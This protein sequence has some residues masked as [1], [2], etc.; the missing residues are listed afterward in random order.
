[1]STD[2][3]LAT[4]RDAFVDLDRARDAAE[5]IA[6]QEA[7]A[8]LAPVA[9]SKLRSY[10]LLE[11]APGDAVLDVGCGSGY[12]V[13]AL[14]RLVAPGRAVG[15]DRSRIA[16]TRAQERHGGP[17]AQFAVADAG[18]LPFPDSSFAAARSERALQHM[19]APGRALAEMARVTR[20][21]GRV[22]AVEMRS[23][24]VGH[25]IL[26]AGITQALFGHV[27]GRSGWMGNFLPPL[28]KRAGLVDV[29]LFWH[30]GR[31]AGWDAL[32]TVFAFDL[33]LDLAARLSTVDPE[34]AERWAEACRQ[35]CAAGTLAAQMHVVLAAGR[36]P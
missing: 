6:H 19:Q 18:A 28:F 13:A 22:V 30:E 5:L 14:A 17:H 4:L 10:E 16:I 36:V 11:L 26:D 23:V 33:L 1:V 20:P 12:D 7:M 15:V 35:A 31:V 27:E 32:R 8:Q 25:D 9:Q 21:G 29:E 24:L 3:G 2:D 34:R